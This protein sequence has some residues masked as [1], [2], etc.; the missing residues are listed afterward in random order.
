ML[1]IVNSPVWVWDWVAATVTETHPG[2]ILIEAFLLYCGVAL[3]LSWLVVPKATLEPPTTDVSSVYTMES[4]SLYPSGYSGGDATVGDFGSQPFPD[5]ASL[6]R[7][8]EELGTTHA[9]AVVL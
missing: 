8:G 5:Q 9:D 3:L 7:S 6:L 2:L 1:A 4:A